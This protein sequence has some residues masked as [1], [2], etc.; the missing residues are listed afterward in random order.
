MDALTKKIGEVIGTN[1][2]TMISGNGGPDGLYTVELG[3][4]KNGED[5]LFRF[6]A[7]T[8]EEAFLRAARRLV[9][10]FGVADKV[11][12]PEV[13]AVYKVRVWQDVEVIAVSPQDARRR[14]AIDAQYRSKT[15]SWQTEDPELLSQMVI[16]DEALPLPTL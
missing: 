7:P 9:E 5:V 3:A 8:E 6:R 13:P 10:H 14:A 2:G 4:N 16:D 11:I 1:V 12:I 15:D